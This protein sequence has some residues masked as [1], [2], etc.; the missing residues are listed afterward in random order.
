MDIERL[1]SKYKGKFTL[2]GEVDGQNVQAFGNPE[3]VYKAVMRIR[4]SFYNDKGG[5]IAQCLCGKGNPKENIKAVY[6]A[7]NRV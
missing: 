2:W 7:W 1:G 5:I 6:E 4:K 3:D